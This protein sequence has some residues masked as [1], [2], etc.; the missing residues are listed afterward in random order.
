ME[1]I[2]VLAAKVHIFKNAT[3]RPEKQSYQKKEFNCVDFKK[4]VKC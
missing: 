4:E 1:M 2:V 3:R